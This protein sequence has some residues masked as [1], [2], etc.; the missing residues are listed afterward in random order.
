MATK[1]APTKEAAELDE[2]IPAEPAEETSTESKTRLYLLSALAKDGAAAIKELSDLVSQV[3]SKVEKSEDLG[4]KRLAFAINKQRQLTLVSVFF[5]AST[6]VLAELQ[7]E[8]KHAETL[9][10]YLLTDWK[11]DLNAPARRP[12][13]DE[14]KKESSR[15]V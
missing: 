12:R 5:N 11:A 7:A 2:Q 1:A 4:L 10:R 15:D 8:L 13:R 6:A 14:V 3:G 9:E